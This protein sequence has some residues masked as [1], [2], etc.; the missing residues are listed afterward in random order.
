[1][2]VLRNQLLLQIECPICYKYMSPPIRVCSKGHST[3]DL[4][5][6]KHQTCVKCQ[7]PF[8]TTRN[9][10]LEAISFE[11]DIQC[12]NC[13]KYF[14]SDILYDHICQEIEVHQEETENNIY[15]CRIS[16]L[17]KNYDKTICRWT[18]FTKD[19]NEHFL[20]Q[21]LPNYF[22]L[23][24]SQTFQWTLPYAQDQENIS[25]VRKENNYFL[26][27][28]LYEH[29]TKLLYFTI[30]D[31]NDQNERFEFQILVPKKNKRSF[32]GSVHKKYENIQK[33]KKQ[34]NI[35]EIDLDVFDIRK[36]REIQWILSINQQ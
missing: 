22:V 18:G 35:L 27:E 5:T 8:L 24:H 3:C 6:K 17:D 10:A 33:L 12:N 30:Y 26:Q 2:D 21:H 7:Y 36:D 15:L 31:I 9:L 29:K 20:S 14:T 34:E 13:K 19:I 25:V 28:V 23:E 4:C 1:M 11:L 32:A 16:V